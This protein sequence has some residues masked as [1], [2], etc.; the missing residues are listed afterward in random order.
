MSRIRVAVAL[1]LASAGTGVVLL[2]SVAGATTSRPFH[3][4]HRVVVEGLYVDHWTM[5]ET[6]PCGRVGDGTVTD[7]K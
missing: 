4:S 5:D 7:S 1:L 3:Y 6:F 2:A